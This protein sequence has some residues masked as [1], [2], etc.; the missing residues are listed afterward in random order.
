MA[1]EKSGLSRKERSILQDEG[2]TG[3]G[4]E[5]DYFKQWRYRIKNKIRPT[6][7][8]TILLLKHCDW[9]DQKEFL[10]VNCR[11]DLITLKILVQE[12]LSDSNVEGVSTIN[13]TENLNKRVS[14]TRYDLIGDENEWMYRL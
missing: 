4:Q 11:E 6:I 13:Q 1:N 10:Q 5:K 2:I 9:I 12:L 7:T 3:I 14:E 8:D